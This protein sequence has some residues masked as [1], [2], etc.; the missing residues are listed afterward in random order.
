VVAGIDGWVWGRMRAF[1]ALASARAQDLD[2]DGL[3]L[4]HKA[5]SHLALSHLDLSH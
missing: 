1:V 5:L 4:S 3:S 2:E